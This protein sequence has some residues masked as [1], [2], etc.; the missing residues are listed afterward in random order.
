MSLASR[1]EALARMYCNWVEVYSPESHA[2]PILAGHSN[3]RAPPAAH[4][5][6][7]TLQPSTSIYFHSKDTSFASNAFFY[8]VL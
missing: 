2:V 4:S 5:G 1:L 7:E 6:H 3:A 8:D